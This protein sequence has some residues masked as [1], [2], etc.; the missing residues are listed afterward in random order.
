[1]FFCLFE[2]SRNPEALQ[3]VQEELDEV[4]KN[5]ETDELTY[6]TLDQ[7]TYLDCCIME[8]LRLY[9]SV[10]FIFRECSKD[11]NVPDSKLVIPKGTSVFVPLMGLHR[12]PEIFENPLQFKPERFLNSSNGSGNSKGLFY[13]PFGDGPRICIGMRLGKFSAKLGLA[14]ILSKFNFE[15]TDKEM[16]NEVLEFHPNQ[17]I[18]NPVKAFNLKVTVR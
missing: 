17:A 13:L 2:L 6:K 14:S 3:K 10:P 5:S 12:D 8:T 9:P 4:S 1:M 15:L 7:L 18:L 16:M 11:Y